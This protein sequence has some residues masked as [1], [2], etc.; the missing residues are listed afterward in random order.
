M[1]G[2]L[3]N[4]CFVRLLVGQTVS[5]FGDSALYLSLAIWAKDLTGSDA[6]AGLVLLSLA[7]P[8]LAAPFFGHLV[9]RVRRKR[10]L[11]ITHAA[12]G[13]LVLS[14]LAVRSAEQLWIIHL[15]AA[16]HGV[17]GVIPAHHALLK[18]VLPSAEAAAARSW[19]IT[20][21]QGVRIVSPAVGAAVCTAA[22]GGALAL[23]NAATF[24]VALATLAGLRVAESPP[25]RRG[26]EPVRRA[27]LAGFRHVRDLPLL[28]RLTLTQAAF[29]AVAGLVETAAF[30]AI[31]AL[32]RPPAFFGVVV[33][34]QGAGSV[35]AGLLAVVLVG[36][37]GEAL[38][39]GLAYACLATG[40]LLCAMPSLPLF[41]AGAV[42]IGMGLPLMSV[43]LGIAQHLYTPPRLQGRVGAAVVMLCDG[44]QTLSI[45]AGAALIGLV[46]HRLLYVTVAAVAVLCAAAVVTDRP[47]SPAIAPSPA[48][49]TPA[50]PAVSLP[51]APDTWAACC[52]RSADHSPDAPR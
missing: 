16:G 10:L 42:L 14:L 50:P 8:G 4:P 25:E 9:D 12:M 23:V 13:L 33:A 43:S 20:S 52:S 40:M 41:L 48:D 2:P 29:M 31:E 28:R 45:A 3:G 18:D 38:T 35:V 22:G 24:A 32:G 26:G 7:A 19:L 30:A 27:M 15:V 51:P 1:N 21:R 46:D 39:A 37:A 6:A 34:V 5:A 36:R 11:L 47:P 17:I 49:R 44:A